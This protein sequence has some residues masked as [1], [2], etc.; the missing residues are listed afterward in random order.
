MRFMLTGKSNWCAKL[1]AFQFARWRW[2]EPLKTRSGSVFWSNQQL[3]AFACWQ[4]NE[5]RLTEPLAR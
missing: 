1:P 2:L 4:L 3:K 5:P